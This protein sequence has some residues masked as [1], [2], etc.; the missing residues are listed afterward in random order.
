MDIEKQLRIVQGL[1]AM[2]LDIDSNYLYEK[3]GIQ[4]P[5]DAQTSL[6]KV[7]KEAL[8]TESQNQPTDPDTADPT[9]DTTPNPGPDPDQDLIYKESPTIY[10][11]D[12]TPTAEERRQLETWHRFFVMGADK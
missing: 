3:F 11:K 4:K 10:N 1:Y 6:A 5:D 7:A 8:D 2:G 12:T 9:A